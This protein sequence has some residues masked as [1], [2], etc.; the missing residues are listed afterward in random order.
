MT[1]LPCELKLGAQDKLTDREVKLII[2]GLPGG[3]GTSAKEKE[4]CFFF[5]F[6][7]II[8]NDALMDIV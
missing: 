7:N 1:E 8:I 3:S 5:F 6:T 4:T 2:S